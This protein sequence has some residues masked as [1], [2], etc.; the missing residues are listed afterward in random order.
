MLNIS[1]PFR[2]YYFQYQ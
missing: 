1:L 2:S